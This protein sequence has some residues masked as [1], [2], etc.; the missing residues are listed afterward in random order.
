[1]LWTILNGLVQRDEQQGQIVEP[2]FFGG[3]AIEEIAEV[4]NISP[5][6]V[7]RDRNV[8]QAWL[9]RQMKRGNRDHA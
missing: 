7:K 9:T 8:A 1:L 6:P 3:L 2:R 4:R 5:S